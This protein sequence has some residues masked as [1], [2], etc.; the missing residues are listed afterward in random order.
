MKEYYIDF[1]IAYGKGHQCCFNGSIR[2][3]LCVHDG[4]VMAM[5][6]YC[7]GYQECQFTAKLATAEVRQLHH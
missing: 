1:W 6:V 4:T 7:S 3:L 2:F 5:C